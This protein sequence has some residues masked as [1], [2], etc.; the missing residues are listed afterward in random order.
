MFILQSFNILNHYIL[1][2]S[3]KSLTD[4]YSLE[5]D[6][7]LSRLKPF[8]VIQE[9]NVFKFLFNQI[10]FLFKIRQY[11]DFMLE[12]LE[13]DGTDSTLITDYANYL[14]EYNDISYIWNFW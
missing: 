7:S 8:S 5:D 1:A 10:L 14:K 13:Y 4:K 9:W 11:C 6:L 3:L 12:Y 2:I